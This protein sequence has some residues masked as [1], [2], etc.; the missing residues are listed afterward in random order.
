MIAWAAMAFAL[1][2]GP[3]GGVTP[4]PIYVVDAQLWTG[5]RGT[6]RWRPTMA[7]AVAARAA[8]RRYL[9][10]V[11]PPGLN[12]WQADRAREVSAAFDDYTFQAESVRQSDKGISR[13]KAT[14]TG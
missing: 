1:V 7:Q 6:G 9:A 3:A 2:A 11:P 13:P 5:R 10:L 12:G 14:S 4:P 8:L